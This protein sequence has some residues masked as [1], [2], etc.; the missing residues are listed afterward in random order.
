MSIALLSTEQYLLAEDNIQNYCTIALP[1]ICAIN[2]PNVTMTAAE[3]H[4]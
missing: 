2:K 3:I 4:V 1:Q